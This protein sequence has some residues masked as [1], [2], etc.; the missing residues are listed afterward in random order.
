MSRARRPDDGHG[1]GLSVQ[2]R[3]QPGV[4]ARAIAVR[5]DE[6]VLGGE[7]LH[8]PA[9]NRRHELTNDFADPVQLPSLPQANYG[10]GPGCVRRANNVPLAMASSGTSR[11]LVDSHPDS[12]SRAT[13]T[14][15]AICKLVFIRT[16]HQVGR[17]PGAV[18]AQAHAPDR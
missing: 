18:P 6:V 5:G 11:S 7:G 14:I 4:Y 3:H 17:S 13:Q 10:P 8:L 2:G 1:P 9:E 15:P 16:A 12:S